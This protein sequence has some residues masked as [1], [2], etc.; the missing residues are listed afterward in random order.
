MIRPHLRCL[1]AL[2]ACVTALCV[3]NETPADDSV[4]APNPPATKPHNIPPKGFVALFNGKDLAGWQGLGHFDPRKLR[5]MSPADRIALWEKNHIDLLEHWR[6][7]DGDLVND[8]NGV[9]ATTAKEYGD[10]ELLIDY[11]TVAN[12]DSGIYL[13][14]TPQVQIWDTTEAGGKWKHGADKGSGALWNNQQHERFP[15]VLADNPFGEWNRFRIRMVGEHV[16][17]WMND[18]LT[19]KEVPL[20][21][22]WD[23]KQPVF[24]VGPIQLQTHGGEIRWRN[25]FIKEIPRRPPEAGVLDKNG[26]PV[27]A[28]WTAGATDDKQF[29]LDVVSQEPL[30]NFELHTFVVLPDSGAK[31]VAVFRGNESAGYELA[32]DGDGGIRLM[33]LA[34]TESRLVAS[35][36]A[37]SGGTVRFGKPNHL[38]LRVRGDYFEAWLNGTKVIDAIDSSGP[39]QG[40]L[41]LVGKTPGVKFGNIFYRTPPPDISGDFD[42]EEG[43]VSLFNGKD[44]TGWTGATKNYLVEHGVLISP[45]G[46]GGNLYYDKQFSDF[47]LRFEF[48]LES[49][50]NNGVGIRAEQG[51][52]AA[53]HGME[54][55]ILDNT[56][57]GYASLKPYQY[58]GSIYGVAQARRGFQQPL[59]YWNTEEIYANGNHIRVTLN[60]EV[61][62]DV[63]IEKVGKP[64]TIDGRNHPGLF[65]KAGYIGFL[66]HGHEIKFRNIRIKQLRPPTD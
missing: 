56:S 36:S 39:K 58:H 25:V 15:Y 14:A 53:Y 65:N 51:K 3:V 41:M 29:R 63:D 50:G 1:L 43:F 7:E 23:R 45:K 10:F 60:G 5:A 57:P 62:V 61:I 24:P 48:A 66:G 54:I 4:E 13:R 20:D 33:D 35:K 32:I 2:C 49:G 18:Q 31:A 16:T 47:V 17:V 34:A 55:Q 38:Y 37:A 64:K 19:V 30:G 42:S 11:K 46:R 26:K 27:G 22:F 40:R 59:G 12:A 21:N 8:G 9:Y 44:L 52:D 28:G 6:V